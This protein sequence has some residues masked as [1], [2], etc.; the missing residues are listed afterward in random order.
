MAQDILEQIPELVYVVETGQE[1]YPQTPN[2]H[3]WCL[4]G[5]GMETGNLNELS[6][7][8]AQNDVSRSPPPI[9]PAD[10]TTVPAEQPQ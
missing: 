10:M 6:T 9:S 5:S 8:H 7:S 3:Q 4:V 2:S 1:L